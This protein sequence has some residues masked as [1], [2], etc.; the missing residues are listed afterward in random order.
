MARFVTT[1]ASRDELQQQ[2]KALENALKA[3]RA[4]ADAEHRRAEAAEQSSRRAWRLAAWQ[5]PRAANDR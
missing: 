4:R 3:E 1:D 5:G 2:V